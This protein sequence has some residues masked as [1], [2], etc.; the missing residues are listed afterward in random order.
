MH[1][2]HNLP[3]YEDDFIYSNM[4]KIYYILAILKE[5]K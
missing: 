5:T 2:D 3:N 4:A 1:I